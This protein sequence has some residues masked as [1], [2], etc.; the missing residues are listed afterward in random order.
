VLEVP[1]AAVSAA[2]DTLREQGLPAPRSGGMSFSDARTA[3]E[4]L[5][6]QERRLRLDERR[7]RVVEKSKA[8]LLVR[9]LAI[10]ERDAILAWPARVASVLA[11]ELGVN[12]HR[13]Q[14]LLDASLREHLMERHDVRISLG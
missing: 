1:L 9:R 2:A 14:T 13:L 11:A 4:I 3:S 7:G 12:A 8:L 10:E 5:K 6:I